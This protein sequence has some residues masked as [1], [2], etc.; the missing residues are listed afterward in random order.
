MLVSEGQSGARTCAPPLDSEL[1]RTSSRATA[2][3]VE[4]G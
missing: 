1:W 3:W 4:N 2:E